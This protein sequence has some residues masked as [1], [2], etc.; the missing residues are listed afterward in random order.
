MGAV[1]Q[2]MV[3]KSTKWRQEEGTL[4]P[5]VPSLAVTGNAP[6]SAL[7]WGELGAVLQLSAPNSASAQMSGA[8]ADSSLSTSWHHGVLCDACLQA[9]NAIFHGFMC[10][11]DR[12]SPA[13]GRD[14]QQL[15]SA[16]RQA[17]QL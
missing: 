8:A 15:I 6:P 17:R 13:T 12:C 9:Q 14:L 4:Q 11:Q 2:D 5:R 7:S 1:F 3:G 16:S 10:L